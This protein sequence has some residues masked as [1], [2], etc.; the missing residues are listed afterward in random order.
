MKRLFLK[1][2]KSN[3][4]CKNQTREKIDDCAGYF[5]AKHLI[6]I[7]FSLAALF[8]ISGKFSKSHPLVCDGSMV[9][10]LCVKL[11]P[12]KNIEKGVEKGISNSGKP[13]VKR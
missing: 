1:Q 10:L 6:S 13:F 11:V 2:K 5:Y 4:A 8:W 7:H 9:S 12:I 3:E